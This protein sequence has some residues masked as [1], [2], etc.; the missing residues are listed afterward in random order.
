[1]SGQTREAKLAVLYRSVDRVIARRRNDAT[2][3]PTTEAER[4]RNLDDLLR[5]LDGEA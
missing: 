4:E 5:G 2:I 1:M 3:S